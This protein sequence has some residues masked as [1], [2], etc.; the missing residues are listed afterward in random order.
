M[1]M[2]YKSQGLFQTQSVV[3]RPGWK[4]SL[5]TS[6]YQEL[7]NPFYLFIR[8]ENVKWVVWAVEDPQRFLESQKSTGSFS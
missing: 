8:V 5:F 6:F 3:S 2:T 7:K 1:I 4:L